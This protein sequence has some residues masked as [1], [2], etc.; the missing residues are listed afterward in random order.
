MKKVK[1]LILSFSAL[2]LFGSIILAQEEEGPGTTECKVS[3]STC[4]IIKYGSTEIKV[5][6]TEIK[7]E[8][9]IIE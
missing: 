3:I 8:E 1:T 2:L 7:K 9:E 4:H 5:P 6:G